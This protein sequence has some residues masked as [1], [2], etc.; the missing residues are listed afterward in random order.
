MLPDAI[1]HGR[2][3]S[4]IPQQ[5]AE[6]MRIIDAIYASSASGQMIRLD[7]EKNG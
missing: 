2:D 7:E 1:E 4:R 6:M 3:I 5:A